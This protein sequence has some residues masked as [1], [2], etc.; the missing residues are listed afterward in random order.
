MKLF[1]RNCY[2]HTS[3]NDLVETMGINRGSM[4]DTFGDKHS[5]F[6]D[7]LFRYSEVYMSQIIW[8]LSQNTPVYPT[9]NRLFTVGSRFLRIIQAYM[10]LLSLRTK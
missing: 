7:C 10:L 3:I 1:W 6:L 9:L 2:E 5:L 4:Y 8:V